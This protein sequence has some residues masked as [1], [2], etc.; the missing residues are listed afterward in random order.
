MNVRAVLTITLI[1]A[2]GCTLGDTHVAPIP[3]EVVLAHTEVVYQ[4]AGRS[5]RQLLREMMVLG[6]KEAGESFFAYT[7]WRVRLQIRAD[8]ARG[9][10][11]IAEWR[12]LLDLTTILPEWQV[13]GNASPALIEKWDLFLSALRRHERGHRKLAAEGAR[14]VSHMLEKMAEAPCSKAEHDAKQAAAIILASARARS[15]QFDRVTDHG[16]TEGAGWPPATR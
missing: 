14:K 7:R 10:C 4:I 2:V 1:L 12:V 11:E 5:E 8:S 3:S 15:S 9:Y 13:P 6:P 16:M